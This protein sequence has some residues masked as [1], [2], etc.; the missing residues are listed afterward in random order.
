MRRQ[1]GYAALLAGLLLGGC[2]LAPAYKAPEVPL[3][4]QYRNA[5]PWTPARPADQLPREGWWQ[6]YGDAQL[7]QLEQRLLQRNASLEAALAHYQQSRALLA[8]VRSDLFPHLALGGSALRNRQSD[9]RPLRGADSPSWYNAATLGAT[10]G[11]EVD[12]WGRVSNAVAAGSAEE[13]AAAA[14]LASVRLSLEAQLADSYLALLGLDRQLELLRESVAAYEHA[15]R[16]TQTL[17]G[18]GIVSGLDTS[19]AQTQLSSARSLQGQ[20]QGQR[21]L[22][23]HAIAVL[24]G[25]SASSFSL[26]ALSTLPPVPAIPPGV[27]STLLQRRPD[28]AAAERRVAEANAQIGVARAAWFPALTL[29]VQGGFQSDTYGG[30]LTASNLFW[31]IGPAL[32]VDLFDGGRREAVVEQARAATDEAGAKYRDVVLAAFQQV[33]DSQSLLIE[34]GAALVDQAAAA[35]AA[36]HTLDMSLD[37]YKQ[38]AVSYLD[39]TVAQTA[40]LQAQMSLLDLQSRQLR[41]SV[42]L[43]RALG[44]GWSVPQATAQGAAAAGDG[45]A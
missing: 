36:Q 7:D 40:A 20:I 5:G 16:M 33:E 1:A 2:S 23:E 11:Y 4:A 3:A 34:Q 22:L 42:Q 14:D 15:L 45:G 43:V 39:V 41:A 10:A 9:T 28:I 12:L 13:Q 37:R 29:G 32:A 18:A 17:H 26:A 38:G 6:L 30:L 35:D 44:G 8:Q 25:E 31:A 27:P 19:R 24:V 21:E